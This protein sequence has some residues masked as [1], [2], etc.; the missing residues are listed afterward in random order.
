MEGALGA[1]AGGTGAGGMVVCG[2]ASD[3]KRD[4]RVF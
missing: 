4:Q 3:A 1:R 2:W